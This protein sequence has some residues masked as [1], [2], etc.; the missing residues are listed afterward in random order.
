[1]NFIFL[2]FLV[3]AVYAGLHKDSLAKRLPI[4]IV[5][6]YENITWEDCTSPAEFCNHE[7]KFDNYECWRWG[8][9]TLLSWGCMQDECHRK[10]Y[11]SNNNFG[12]FEDCMSNAY[13]V[14]VC[15]LCL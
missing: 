15:E 2:L 12:S 10:C 8:K 3:A 14:C 7:E 5:A 9:V 13:P 11:R 1:M 4:D 6:K